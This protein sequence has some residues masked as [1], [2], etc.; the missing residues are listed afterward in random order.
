MCDF[1]NLSDEQKLLHHE[2]L[3]KCAEAFGGVNFFLQ[4]LEGIRKAKPHPLSARSSS[5]SLEHGSV[6]WNK[7]VFQD[8]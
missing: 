1:N 2:Q 5:F 4:L 8:M 7:I 6:K 3:L